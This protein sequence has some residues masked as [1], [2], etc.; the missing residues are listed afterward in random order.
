V[1]YNS[2]SEIAS[3]P[4]CRSMTEFISGIS[5]VRFAASYLVALACEAS[6][7]LF[8]SGPARSGSRGLRHRR[9]SRPYAVSRLEG[10]ERAGSSALEPFDRYLLAA[11]L[12][13]GSY[14]W[15]PGEPAARQVGLFLLPVV[16]GLVGPR[17]LSSR[18]SVSAEP[19]HAGVGR[20][21]RLVQRWRRA[22]PWR[23]A[24]AGLMWLDPGHTA[25][26]QPTPAQGLRLPSLELLAATT[27]RAAGSP[28]GPRPR[29]SARGSCSTPSIGNAA[30][31]KPCP[32]TIL[33]CSG[34]GCSSPG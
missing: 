20:H 31:S 9:I 25:D 26:P 28:P 32:G 16:L 18:G 21:S 10:G 29:A 8:R 19:G 2:P 23:G 17:Q 22:S 7:P 6:R 14:L 4:A 33:S 27:G 11:W 5:V 30:C 15:L 34:W 24:V 3:A 1:N 13:A 12:S